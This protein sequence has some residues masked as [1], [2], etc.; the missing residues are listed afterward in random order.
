VTDKNKTLLQILQN[1]TDAYRN[2][3][4][5]TCNNIKTTES[6]G[7]AR[8]CY[9]F[10]ETFG[11]VIKSI[12]PLFG[13]S[14]FEIITTIRNSTGLRP[15]LLVPEVAF[16]L[17]VKRQIRLFEEPSLRCVELIHEEM[18]RIIQ[19]CGTDVQQKLL[20]FPKLNDMI[21][22][23]VTQLLRSRLAIT[24]STVENL[25]QMELAYINTK[26]PDF[27]KDEALSL[28]K[29]DKIALNF[30]IG[31]G[32]AQDSDLSLTDKQMLEFEVTR[33]LIKSYFY[34]VRKSIQDSVPKAICKDLINFVKDNLHFELMTKLYNSEK[35]DGL[36]IE[37]ADIC[38]RRKEVKEML[39]VRFEVIYF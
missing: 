30:E 15:A 3:I 21:F 20:R 13:L 6:C 11:S 32:D 9:I 7:G 17:L 18:Q 1:F 37:A 39:K 23:V 2:T 29:T 31:A 27:R 38:A 28:L 12:Q 33:R 10:H 8:M 19:H 14:K 35:A 24:N 26:H 4:D 36:L 25:L 16:E 34:I 22:D 5:G